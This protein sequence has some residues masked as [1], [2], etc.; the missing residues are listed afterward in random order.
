MSRVINGYTIT[1]VTR[2]TKQAVSYWVVVKMGRRVES[3]LKLA[4]AIGWA[5]K[6]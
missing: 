3:F 5:R 1:K 2:H 4:L 6:H